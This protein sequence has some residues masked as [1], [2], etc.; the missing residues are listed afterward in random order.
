MTQSPVVVE[1]DLPSDLEDFLDQTQSTLH[2][3]TPPVE[4]K[5]PELRPRALR[6]ASPPDFKSDPPS[7]IIPTGTAPPPLG[8]AAT[9]A[10]VVQSSD[11]AAKASA[12]KLLNALGQFGD[13]ERPM[14]E[15]EYRHKFKYI[16]TDCADEVKAE[17]WY[18]NLEYG[19]PAFYW[20]HELIE[21]AEG[22]EAVKKWATLEP[23]IEKR[24]STPS[25]DIK[26]FKKR[27]HNEWEARTFDIEPMLDTLRNPASGT[28]PHF[29]W[30]TYHKSLGLRV[31]IGN[32]ERVANTLRILPTYVINLLPEADQY[33]K[34]FAQLMSDLGGLSSS[35]LLHAYKTW[36]AVEAMRKLSAENQPS[37][38]AYPRQPSPAP[39]SRQRQPTQIT[40]PQVDRQVHFHQIPPGSA[41]GTLLPPLQL[42][43]PVA[44]TQPV[45]HQSIP[46]SQM[47]S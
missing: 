24:W 28:K 21:T 38:F 22:R 45:R 39:P 40:V 4:V 29:E 7:P 8:Y 2:P 3:N 33:D 18:V 16:T 30:A 10:M 44:A 32:A 15:A 17:L 46:P 36:S 27:T 25:I 1:S 37:P 35:R 42:S 13:N 14:N 23:E 9:S 6:F 31:K 34:D 26:A 11:A 12:I 5:S 19:G 47:S 41:R 20:Y 43:N